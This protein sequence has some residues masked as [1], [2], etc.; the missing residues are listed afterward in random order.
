MLLQR[1]LLLRRR[2]LH[3]EWRAHEVVQKVAG[4]RLLLLT[5]GLGAL[6][7]DLRLRWDQIAAMKRSWLRG[8]INVVVALASSAYA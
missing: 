7:E 6:A 4:L 2:G 5:V 8:H 3:T 1:L